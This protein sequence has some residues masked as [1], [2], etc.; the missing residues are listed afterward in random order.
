MRPIPNLSGYYATEDGEIASVRSGSVR[1]LKSQVNRGYHRVT[2][3]VRVNGKRERHRLEVHRLVLMAHAGLP[4][5]DG[6]EARH[7]NGVS[8]DNRPVN[9]AWGTRQQ[10]LED[11]IKHGTRGPGMKALHRRLTDHQV[12]EIRH[13]RAAGE[14]PKVLAEEYGVHREYIPKI[15][16]GKAWS[17]IPINAGGGA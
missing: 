9:L 16:S 10:N 14:S 7:L 17:C 11:A 2:L 12:V 13:R 5:T 8:E 4:Q 15:V 1:V 3:T 6:L